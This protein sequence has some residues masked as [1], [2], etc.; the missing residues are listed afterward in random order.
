MMT[1]KSPDASRASLTLVSDFPDY[2]A[3]DEQQYRR[4]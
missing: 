1:K 4:F 2:E 3:S